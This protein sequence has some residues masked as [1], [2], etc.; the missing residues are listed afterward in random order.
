MALVVYRVAGF[1]HENVKTPDEIMSG[2]RVNGPVVVYDDDN[3]YMGGLIAECVR[4]Q[5]HEV[6]LVT[7]EGV[8]SP[9]TSVTLEQHRIQTRILEKGIK[10]IVSHYVTGFD[11]ATVSL[12]CAF[13]NREHKR[14]A[15]ALIPVTSRDPD[16]DLY[17]G[18]CNAASTGQSSIK[19]ITRIGD[20]A[21][22]GPIAA[23]VFAGHRYARA[24]GTNRADVLRDGI[25]EISA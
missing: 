7:S 5:G 25:P 3:Y 24:L 23:A 10:V 15:G 19:T 14:S 4:E 13:S 6:I 2:A 12:T 1:E 21:A 17:L 18:L 11:G 16:E 8:V 20:C 9:A 22:P